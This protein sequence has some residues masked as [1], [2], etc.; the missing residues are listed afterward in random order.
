MSVR[1][2]GTCGVSDVDPEPGAPHRELLL[3]KGHSALSS[4]EDTI[5]RGIVSTKDVEPHVSA[6]GVAGTSQFT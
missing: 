4:S 3:G 2:V 1:R 6:L 5:I